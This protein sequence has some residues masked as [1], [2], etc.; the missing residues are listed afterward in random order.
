MRR[1]RRVLALL[2][3]FSA[4]FTPLGFFY[5]TI[6]NE[7]RSRYSDDSEENNGGYQTME[8]SEPPETIHVDF[9]KFSED[10]CSNFPPNMTR[11]YPECESKMRWIR[12]GWKTHHCYAENY[13]DGSEC[14]F[15]YYLSQV[16]SYCPLIEKN[17][18]KK[19]LAKISPSIRRLLP[20][21]DTIPNYM[22]TRINRLWKKWKEGAHEVMEKY[23]DSMNNRKKLN[24]LV[25]VGFLANEKTLKLAKKSDHGGPLG[26]LLQWSD[27]LATLSIIGHHLE[28]STDKDSLR[29]VVHKYMSRGPCQYVNGSRQQLD[30]IFTDIMGLNILRQQHRQF[31]MNNRCR[32]RLL[33]SFGTHAEFTNKS[34]FLKNKRDLSGPISQRNPWG[35][36]GLDLRQHWTFYPHSDDNTFLGF[37]VDTEGVNSEEKQKRSY[38]SALV[39]GKEMYMW[40]NAQK[41]IRILKKFVNIYATVA[42]LKEFERRENNGSSIFND[43]QNYGF[44]NSDEISTLLDKTNIFFGLGFPL[45]GPAPLEAMAHGAVFINAKFKEPKSRKNYRFLAEKPTLREWTSQN[46][47]MEKIGEPHVITVDID[48]EEAL[49]AAIKRAIQLKPKPFVPFEFSPAGMLLRV[50]LLLEKQEICDKIAVSKRWPPVDQMK[51]FRTVNPEDSCEIA[52]HSQNL[53]C[54]P[55]YFPIINSS[56]LLTREF[57]CPST[58]ADASPLAPFNCTTQSS[59]SLFSCASR[60][61]PLSDIIRICPCRDYIPQQHAICTKCL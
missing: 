20:I 31:L 26:E 52:C 11:D 2:F 54:E 21:F 18:H 55:S 6:A 8:V 1:R 59:A 40:D 51:I 13:V 43:V 47:Y 34:Y 44:L 35:G 57:S 33:D 48:D 30:I 23:S 38:P 16:E 39:Y 58:S 9:K 29:S 7:S 4:F 42:D 46:P 10:E 3:I 61:P 41:P 12:N 49:E 32:I 19:S 17:T 56:P 5:F 14:S 24:V 50:A 37:V 27:L 60:P 53:L 25:F 45:E 15:R 36:H 22:K 28:V